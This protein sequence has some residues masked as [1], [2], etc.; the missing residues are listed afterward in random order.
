MP[1]RGADWGPKLT[2][3]GFTLQDSL[4]IN[5][6]IKGADNVTVA[7]YALAALQGIRN[8]AADALS[9]DD[10]A[11]LDQLLDTAGPHS[12]LR[13]DDLAV[14]TTRTV[15]AARRASDHTRVAHAAPPETWL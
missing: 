5:V 1:H 6:D 9:A 10:L 15:S 11:A 7:P 2:A 4:T 13:R 3:A 12:I 14:R 8:A